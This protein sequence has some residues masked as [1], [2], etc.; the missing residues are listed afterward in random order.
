[1]RV[2]E[3]PFHFARSRIDLTQRHTAGGRV[4]HGSEEQLTVWRRVLAGQ[5]S[6]FSLERFGV[7]V[8]V[9]EMYVFAVA[10]LVPGDERSHQR[11]NLIQLLQRYRDVNG[12]EHNELYLADPREYLRRL[13]FMGGIP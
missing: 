1:M 8:R 7:E 9:D 4:I 5:G 2:D 11:T 6:E 3:H 13:P 10:V 12:Y